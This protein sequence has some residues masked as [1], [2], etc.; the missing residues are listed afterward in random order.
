MAF[1][2][3]PNLYFQ[4]LGISFLRHIERCL[5]LLYVV[6]MSNDD[7]FSN[8]QALKYELDQYKPG[9]SK[10]VSGVVAN[11]MDLSSS[12]ENLPSFIKAM[13]TDDGGNFN[14]LLL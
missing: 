4:G 6:D 3:L 2:E 8:L 14:E 9:L 5:C 13:N 12:H 7:A 11:K 1:F 10:R